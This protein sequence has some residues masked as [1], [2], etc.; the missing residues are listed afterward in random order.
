MVMVPYDVPSILDQIDELVHVL[1]K[2]HVDLAKRAM[3]RSRARRSKKVKVPGGEVVC[4]ET[5]DIVNTAA[6]RGLRA[7]GE[8]KRPAGI[9]KA[10]VTP[11]RSEG[12]ADVRRVKQ[13]SPATTP[14]EVK[15]KRLLRSECSTVKHFYNLL[16]HCT[17]PLI[18]LCCTKPIF[19][20][21]L[22]KFPYTLLR[23]RIFPYR[24]LFLFF[25]NTTEEHPIPQFLPKSEITFPEIKL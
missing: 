23:S 5:G 9:S 20:I 2:Q 3:M 8:P 16:L 10:P 24:F 18:L 15:K 1:G 21:K 13:I 17:M 25:L 11:L 4:L 7:T 12:A 19:R 22:K 6:N 14:Q